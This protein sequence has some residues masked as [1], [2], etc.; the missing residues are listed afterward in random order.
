MCQS[1]VIASSAVLCI[2]QSDEGYWKGGIF[3][4]E[5]DVPEDYNNKVHYTCVRTLGCV[6]VFNPLPQFPRPITYM[7]VGVL[8]CLDVV[9]IVW[10]SFLYNLASATS[11]TV[12]M[13]IYL[14]FC[15]HVIEYTVCC[16][17]LSW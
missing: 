5:V 16:G 17:V 15:P 3:K 7:Y 12:N 6:G 4:F 2:H 8:F 10:V 13:C 9:C 14:I 1:F 11:C